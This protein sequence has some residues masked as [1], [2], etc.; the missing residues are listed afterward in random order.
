MELGQE[1]FGVLMKILVENIGEGSK[2]Q[3]VDMTRAS[4]RGGELRMLPRGQGTS[5]ILG[6]PWEASGSFRDPRGA[7]GSSGELRG[8]SGSQGKL[9]GALGSFWLFYRS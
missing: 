1:D 8:S 3:A 4:D 6:E 2:G 5:G 9:R 7:M